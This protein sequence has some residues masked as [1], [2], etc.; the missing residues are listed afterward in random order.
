MQFRVTTIA[1]KKGI[2]P[3]FIITIDQ[4]KQLL[5]Y[6]VLYCPMQLESM[7]KPPRAPP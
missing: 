4:S 1:L 5:V 6:A 7:G 2:V 3:N